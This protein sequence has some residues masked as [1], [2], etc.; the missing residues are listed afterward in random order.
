MR[1][2]GGGLVKVRVRDRA[3]VRARVRV[4]VNVRARVRVRVRRVSS[5]PILTSL[6]ATRTLTAPPA[7]SHRGSPG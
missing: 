4:G 6:H 3:W 2:A 1:S 7:A 5:N